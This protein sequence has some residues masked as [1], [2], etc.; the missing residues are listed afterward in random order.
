MSVA[1]IV[2]IIF[3][4]LFVIQTVS[5]YSAQIVSE[6]DFFKK[7]T[8]VQTLSCDFSQE[9]FIAGLKN[10]IRMTGCFYM[11]NDGNIAWIVRHPIRFYCIIYNQKLTSW[12]AES[13]NK[14][15]IDLQDHPAFL[16]MIGM[17]KNFFAGKIE[18]KKD[19]NAVVLSRHKIVLHPL[20]HNPLSDN[21][22]RIQIVLSSERHSISMIEILFSN[23]DR[24]VM[25]FENI[26]I[27]KPIP[28]HIWTTGE[29]K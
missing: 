9:Q 19:Y 7:M 29:S 18:L 12:D 21:V 17:M 27:D 8:K 10:P 28:H 26:M 20:K 6:K 3:F 14:K 22:S 24:N 5:A 25:R 11:T 4:S 13:T 2:K 16:T 1:K 15:V 23:G